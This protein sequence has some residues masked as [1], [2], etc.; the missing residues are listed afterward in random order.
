MPKREPLEMTEET[1]DQMH[2]Q[3]L[4]ELK[5]HVVLLDEARRRL[6]M[7][8]SAVNSAGVR[9]HDGTERYKHVELAI[10]DLQTMLAGLNFAGLAAALGLMTVVDATCDEWNEAAAARHETK[11]EQS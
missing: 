5:R 2:G 10:A 11:P 7:R 9:V 8:Y 1:V 4:D 3:V 6:T